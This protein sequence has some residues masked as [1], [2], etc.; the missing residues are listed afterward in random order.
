MSSKY[1]TYTKKD[2]VRDRDVKLHP[3]WRGVGFALI[4][5]TPIMAY[6]ATLVILDA[7]NANRWVQIPK[8]LLYQ[9][10]DPLLFVKIILTAALIFL[11]GSFFSLITFILYGAFGPK[12]YGPMDVPPTVYKGGRYKR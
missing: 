5:L 3:V 12:R 10:T 4:I 9:G 1:Q 2:D 8:E 6:A 7:N 11:I